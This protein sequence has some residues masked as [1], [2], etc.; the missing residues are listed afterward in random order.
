[1]SV[2]SLCPSIYFISPVEARGGVFHSFIH[3][4]FIAMKEKARG[5]GSVV[6]AM[7]LSVFTLLIL[8]Q[9][10]QRLGHQGK[11][12]STNRYRKVTCA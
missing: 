4:S 7:E 12:F 2:L 11:E 5:I 10:D 1:M 6:S 9:K 8:G 3:S